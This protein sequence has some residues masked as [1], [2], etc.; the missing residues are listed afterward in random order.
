MVVEKES[1]ALSSCCQIVGICDTGNFA[2][3]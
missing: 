2:Y 3:Q 1:D